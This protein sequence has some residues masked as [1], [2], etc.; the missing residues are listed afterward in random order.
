[1]DRQIRQPNPYLIENYQRKGNDCLTD[2]LALGAINAAKIN[3]PMIACLRLWAKKAG[4]AT[5][6]L[7]KAANTKGTK[8]TAKNQ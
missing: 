6:I 7:T 8:N 2:R 1:M 3:I 5:P 4:V